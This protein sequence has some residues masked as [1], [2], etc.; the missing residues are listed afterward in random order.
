MSG[1]VM[2]QLLRVVPSRL[3]GTR[4]SALLAVSP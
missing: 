1:V 3:A 4:V 2:T